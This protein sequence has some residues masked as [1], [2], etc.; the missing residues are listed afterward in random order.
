VTRTSLG[1][2]FG[3]FNTAAVLNGT[4]L[5]FDGGPLLPSAVYLDPGVGLI[6]GRDAERSASLDPARL[7]PN[8]KR[9]ISDGGVYL[10][11]RELHVTDLVAAVLGRV[12]DEVRRVAGRPADEV[13]LT[14][15]AG[16]GAPR[17]A[18]LTEA[19]ARVGW[20]PVR[21]V[22]EPVAAAHYFTSV[23]GVSLPT[24]SCVVI[25]DLGAGTFDA[26]VVRRSPDGFD[27]LATDGLDDAGG[28]DLDAAIVNHLHATLGGDWG[29]LDW[30]ATTAD[31][32]A[33]RL[34]WQDVRAAKEQLSRH[35]SAALHVP[36]LSV[37]AHLTRE[38]FERLARPLL[39]RTVQVT[40]RT[41]HTARIGPESV[42]GM[43]LVGGSSRI[44][45]AAGLLHRELG[46]A[47]TVL[48][49]PELVVAS[50]AAL[51]D[52]RA[53]SYVEAHS[54]V[55]YP[56]GRVATASVSPAPPAVPAPSTVESPAA[57]SPRGSGVLRAIGP[58]ALLAGLLL[59]GFQ[60]G[61]VLLGPST[62]GFS[63][64]AD[65]T[66]SNLAYV[67]LPMSQA[68]LGAVV[69]VVTRLPG[70]WAVAGCGLMLGWGATSLPSVLYLLNGGTDDTW[71]GVPAVA[72]ETVSLLLVGVATVLTVPVLVRLRP[73]VAPPPC[74]GPAVGVWIGVAV[75][76][77]VWL[78]INTQVWEV[79]LDDQLDTPLSSVVFVGL[80]LL[81]L[82]LRPRALGAGI[83]VV[84]LVLDAWWTLYAVATTAD[85]ERGGVPY[86][87]V[88]AIALIGTLVA[89]VGA[90]R[91]RG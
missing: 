30:P 85:S 83:L 48:E 6:T 41:L 4:T 23:L 78:L 90:L 34:L 43:F 40:A 33:R 76:E 46:I 22:A 82:C 66:L 89:A 3:T 2:D 18:V 29:P 57:P 70:Q 52:R 8:P 60:V 87:T 42:A 14:H 15:P 91:S 36:V 69:C 62:E 27:L 58:I 9:R 55:T 31:R 54:G 47:P 44:P 7:E 84:L 50:G 28:L 68:L 35:P 79:E 72:V 38:E 19:A 56:V 53:P 11:D 59:S 39:T 12:A 67:V 71:L 25:Y 10:G 65:D 61:R 16:W 26:A 64:D 24:G 73:T 77:L 49:Q 74:L 80:A 81:A 1:V 21:L 13:V 37:D 63:W 32:R 20:T 51:P 88:Y 5:L 17:R 86:W 75:I 45:L